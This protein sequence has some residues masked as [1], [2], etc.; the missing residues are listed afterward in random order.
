MVF[1]V[2]F[3]L[4]RIALKYNIITLLLIR[5]TTKKC[6]ETFF[7]CLPKK[8]ELVAPGYGCIY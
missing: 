4:F 2:H 8:L 7:G 3:L 5:T 6:V 1:L